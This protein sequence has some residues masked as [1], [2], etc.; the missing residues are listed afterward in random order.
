MGCAPHRRGTGGGRRRAVARLDGARRDV[1]GSWHVHDIACSVSRAHGAPGDVN[2]RARHRPRHAAFAAPYT[3]P[4]ARSTP[5]RR[6]GATGSGP[7]ARRCRRRLRN[8]QRGCGRPTAGASGRRGQHPARHGD[9]DAEHVLLVEQ[10][11]RRHRPGRLRR[12]I[13]TDLRDGAAS[14]RRRWRCGEGAPRL[15]ADGRRGDARLR[16]A[17]SGRRR[18]RS[19]PPAGIVHGRRDA[20]GAPGRRRR[21]LRH[22]RGARLTTATDA[23]DRGTPQ[24]EL[25]R[26]RGATPDMTAGDRRD[27]RCPARPHAGA[28]PR[29]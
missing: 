11:R 12:R 8:G 1:P 28:T 18:A 29:A 17:G 20:D 7:G 21:D 19:R 3:G 26:R 6:P 14:G 10:E 9:A 16:R 27:A 13:S 25:S 23:A 15:H 22:L 2:P 5:G 4:D 24:D